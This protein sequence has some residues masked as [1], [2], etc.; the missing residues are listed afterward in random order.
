MRQSHS[1]FCSSCCSHAP[2]CTS[3]VLQAQTAL[4]TAKPTIAVQ[5]YCSF[6]MIASLRYETEPLKPLLYIA[7]AA[8]HTPHCIFLVLQAQNW[9]AYGSFPLVR[10][11]LRGN[12]KAVAI[13]AKHT[14]DCVFLVLQAQ[15]FLQMASTPDMHPHALQ[16]RVHASDEDLCPLAGEAEIFQSPMWML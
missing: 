5:L 16:G 11:T 6:I 12:F 8:R 4:H 3:L 9:P 14:P 1:S 2:H 10:V 7:V 15:T 13:A